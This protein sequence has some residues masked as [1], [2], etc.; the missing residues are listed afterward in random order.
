MRNNAAI[1]FQAL[2]SDSW[3]VIT[4]SRDKSFAVA[5]EYK[6]PYLY[7]VHT[8]LKGSLNLIYQTK[9]SPLLEAFLLVLLYTCEIFTLAPSEPLSKTQQTLLI[10]PTA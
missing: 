1:N 4:L 3:K 10:S 6:V 7:L 8:A 5:P 9:K 2:C